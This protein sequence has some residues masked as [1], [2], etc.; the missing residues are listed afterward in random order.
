VP[1]DERNAE[2]GQAQAQH[3]Q[4]Q[5]DQQAQGETMR[6]RRRLRHRQHRRALLRVAAHDCGRNIKA[7]FYVGTLLQDV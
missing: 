6:R 5:A 2:A 4:Q 7:P 1:Q 3:G